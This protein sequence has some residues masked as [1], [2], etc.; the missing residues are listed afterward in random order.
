MTHLFDLTGKSAL[1]TGGG[2]GL[3][4]AMAIALAEAGADIAIAG[5]SLD[6]LNDCCADL[7]ACNVRSLAIEADLWSKTVA[8]M[9]RMLGESSS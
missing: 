4:R 9:S 6:T 1:V 2:R 3:G 7:D 8:M 5:R